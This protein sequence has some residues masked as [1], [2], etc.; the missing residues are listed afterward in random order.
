MHR[1]GA[2]V[3]IWM[4]AISAC[5]GADVI[6]LRY[7]ELDS[8]TTGIGA[9]FRVGL[10]FTATNREKYSLRNSGADYGGVTGMIGV[11]IPVT[12]QFKIDPAV[13]W[14]FFSST[15]YFDSGIGWGL[16]LVWKPY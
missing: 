10:G 13:R 11:E 16:H 4:S 5:S 9:D 2:A 12:G 14:D 3:A 7:M 8:S 15:D 1:L 6:P